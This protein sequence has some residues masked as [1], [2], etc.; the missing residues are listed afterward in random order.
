MSKSRS[1]LIVIICITLTCCAALMSSPVVTM[2]GP[3]G[4]AKHATAYVQVFSTTLPAQP[5]IEI[6]EITCDDTS[7]NWNMKQILIKAREIGADAIVLKGGMG[8]WGVS[9]PSGNGAV[10]LSEGYGLRAVAIRWKE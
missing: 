6:A 10:A 1:G 4:P 7:N 9:V 8:A 5:Y 2:F 3:P